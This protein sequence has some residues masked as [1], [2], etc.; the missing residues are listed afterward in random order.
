[1]KAVHLLTNHINHPMGMDGGPLFLSWQ[2][3]GGICQSAWELVLEADG[4]IV[5]ESGVKKERTMH[6]NVPALPQI[7]RSR[8]RGRWR[9]RLYDENGAAGPWSAAVFETGL[10][11]EDWKA[12]VVNPE[13]D[14]PEGQ[15]LVGGKDPDVKVREDAI[16]AFARRNWEEKEAAKE[17]EGKGTAQP[18]V[19]HRP[20]S[21]LRKTFRVPVGAG[22]A[23][24]YITAFGLYV[25]WI[26]G[27][28]ASDMV[29]A[30][31]SFAG[32]RQIGAQTYDV[33]PLLREGENEFVAALGDGWHRSTSGVDGDRNLF[34]E[35]VGLLFQLEVDGIV[36]CIS[37]ES[38]EAMQAGPIRQ[39]DLQQG[40]VYD[41]RKEQNLPQIYSKEAAGVQQSDPSHALWHGVMAKP[42]E[43]PIVG[44]NTVP[45]RD[46][47]AFPGRLF[48][49]PNGEWALD[50]GQNLAGYIEIC[51]QA[52][53]GERIL[54]TCAETLDEHGNVT[55]ENFQD[56]K[57]HKE[58]GTAQLLELF[59]REGENHF[60]P[61]FTI[62]GFRYARVEADM[63]LSGAR[64][65]AHAVYSDMQMTGQFTCGNADVNQLVCNSIWSQKGNFCDIP[66]DCPTRERAG[67]TGDMGVFI[68]TGLTFMDCYPVVRKWLSQ[69]RLGQYPDGR[70]ANI[71]PPNSR[72][73]FMTPML[74][75]SAGWGDASILVPYAMYQRTGD[76]Q[77]LE[78]NYDMMQRWYAFLL[79]RA[80]E[81]DPE[82]E[83]GEYAQYTVLSGMDYGEWCEPG[84]SPMQ[85]M[86]NPR[87]SVGTAYLAYSGQL[88]AEIA[89]VLG[90]DEDAAG[91]RDISEKARRAYREAFTEG[92]CIHSD[93]QCEYV[94]PIAFGLLSDKEC[95][96]AADTLDEMVRGNN[97]HL[98]T[99]FLST[100]HL[101]RVLADYGHADTAYRLL[102]Q[103][104]APGWLYEVRKGATTVWE[105]WNGIDESGAPHESL[106]HYSYGA[107]CGWLFGGVCGIRLECGA[108]TIAP[109]P[110]PSLGYAKAIYDS[111]VGR[112]VSN[113]R[114]EGDTL[115][116][117]FEIPV[118]VTARICLAGEEPFYL[119]PGR[120]TVTRT[121]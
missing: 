12:L 32:D 110:E 115:R 33:T 74:C 27:Q 67:W 36:V 28:R 121:L 100:P 118:N 92:G 90:R 26:N 103:T 96:A 60:K 53:E 94:R 21:Y 116:Y 5:W 59:C 80:Q 101:C 95:R 19:P 93:R 117:C 97:D 119:K 55:Q 24:L 84:I 42:P 2:C 20:A 111:P 83:T 52:G 43:I 87:K 109:V 6:T 66:T 107:V 73:G 31:G 82:K 34:G 72:P 79:G 37:D 71:A 61:D 7:T 1:M 15:V 86:S 22:D 39:N 113:W 49:T 13:K 58:G 91:Y 104:E 30:P 46:Q 62:M 47:E 88:L 76:R 85:A 10:R 38:M 70:M 102:L 63:D 98:N 78:E 11:Q 48:R 50:F 18:Y 77:I 54:L 17:A 16:N 99:G 9:V 40:E 114:Y 44:M 3:E 69:C 45:I 89:A 64:F 4:E 106:N 105:T 41:A 57:R 112:I 8:V 29:L 68:D 51:V 75:M 108:L 14:S 81:T 120:H 25:V 23:R 65:T 56:R 35:H